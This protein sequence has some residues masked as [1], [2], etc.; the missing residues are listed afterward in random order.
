MRFSVF[1]PTHD[2]KY[3]LQAHSSLKAQGIA[4]WEWIIQPNGQ[5]LAPTFAIPEADPC[6]PA[7]CAMLPWCPADGIG[8]LKKTCCM[9]ARGDLLLEL[10]HDD[11]LTPNAFEEIAKTR[12]ETGAD[13]IYSDS[14]HFFPDDAAKSTTA[15]RL[16]ALP[17]RLRAT[18]N[19]S[20]II[21]SR[22]RPRSICEIF[23]RPTMC[24]FG[25]GRLTTSWAATAAGCR[26]ATTTTSCAAPTWPA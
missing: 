21:P 13:F 22:P 26:S 15:A 2:P 20:S 4:D 25:P 11:Y 1:T 23:W 8:G 17:L 3:L 14:V 9:N 5:T 7:R 12:T 24:G 16:E 18:R 6:R 10:D 19:T